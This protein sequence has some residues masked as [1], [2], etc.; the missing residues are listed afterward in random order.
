[1]QLT[2]VT[3]NLSPSGYY[4]YVNANKSG[5]IQPPLNSTTDTFVA[6]ASCQYIV[7]QVLY[8]QPYFFSYFTAA[9]STTF[10]GQ[11]VSVLMSSTTFKSE[12]YSGSAVSAG[13]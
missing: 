12:P 1:M 10:N 4:S 8:P 2:V 13:C 6:G 9:N 11:S 3:P 5:L 7:L